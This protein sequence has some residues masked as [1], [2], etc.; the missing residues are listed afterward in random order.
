M[1]MAIKPSSHIVLNIQW[2]TVDF[3]YYKGC[4]VELVFLF[5]DISFCTGVPVLVIFDL[6]GE[7]LS[8]C[9]SILGCTS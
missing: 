2:N 5:D 3:N 9:I 7:L 8:T 6:G 4:K 1:L